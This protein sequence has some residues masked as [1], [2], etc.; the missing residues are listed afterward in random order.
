ME[1]EK[2]VL[3]KF[4]DFFCSMTHTLTQLD[5]HLI[6]FI[7]ESGWNPNNSHA[8]YNYVCWKETPFVLVTPGTNSIG[9]RTHWHKVSGSCPETGVKVCVGIYS[10]YITTALDHIVQWHSPWSTISQRFF[11]SSH[12]GV[13]GELCG[14]IW[15]LTTKIGSNHLRFMWMSTVSFVLFAH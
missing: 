15:P 14:H 4:P 2:T 10:E 9:C 12:F 13:K 3:R 7:P 11:T 1:A 5:S 6:R 8:F